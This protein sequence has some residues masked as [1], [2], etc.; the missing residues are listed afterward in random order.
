MQALGN[1]LQNIKPRLVNIH[2]RT[3]SHSST[4]SNTLFPRGRQ[5]KQAQHRLPSL[6]PCGAPFCATPGKDLL[7]KA[8]S[9]VV[10]ES[11]G[12]LH[13]HSIP[14]EAAGISMQTQTEG[15]GREGKKQQKSLF[16]SI[17]DGRHWDFPQSCR[18]TSK[19]CCCL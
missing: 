18:P 6:A 12:I 9:W 15:Q 14:S 1:S 11:K 5:Y 4:C 17:F 13:Y 16:V 10:Q 2:T 7:P 8:P 3:S 19:A